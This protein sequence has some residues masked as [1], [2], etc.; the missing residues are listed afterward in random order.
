MK[1]KLKGIW[2]I[3]LALFGTLLINLGSILLFMVLLIPMLI[4]NKV[5]NLYTK[6]FITIYSSKR[7]N[8]GQNS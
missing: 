1:S 5:Y 2:I 8:N 3:L 4:S 7:S 6:T